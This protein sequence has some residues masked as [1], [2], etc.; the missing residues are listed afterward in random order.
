MVGFDEADRSVSE[1]A[2]TIQ[3]AV[4]LVQE[5]AVLVTV[6]VTVISGTAVEGEGQYSGNLHDQ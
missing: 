2:G 1:S 6:D 3:V 5:V 4:T